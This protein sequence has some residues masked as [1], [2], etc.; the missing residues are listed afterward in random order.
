MSGKSIVPGIPHEKKPDTAELI[1]DARR[2]LTEQIRDLIYL[3][4]KKRLQFAT[5]RIQDRAGV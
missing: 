3:C 5:I 1:Q 2:V 4:K